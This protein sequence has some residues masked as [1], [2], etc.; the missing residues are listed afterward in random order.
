MKNRNMCLIFFIILGLLFS[1]STNLVNIYDEPYD[2]IVAS[3]KE[4]NNKIY[5]IHRNSW[6][7][8]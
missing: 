8:S 7:S 5:E 1:P 4:V 6:E 3:L 2:L